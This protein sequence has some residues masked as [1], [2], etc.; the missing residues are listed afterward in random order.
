MVRN[1]YVIG[2]RVMSSEPHRGGLPKGDWPQSTHTTVSSSFYTVNFTIIMAKQRTK[3]SPKMQAPSISKLSA[4]QLRKLQK[5]IDKQLE[6]TVHKEEHVVIS[7]DDSGPENN[8]DVA[9]STDDDEYYRRPEKTEIVDNLHAV[10]E[11]SGKEAE[12]SEEESSE[13]ESSEEESSEEESSEEES[14]EEKSFEEEKSLDEEADSFE[15]EQCSDEEIESLEKGNYSEDEQESSQVAESLNKKAQQPLTEDED[16]SENL[17]DNGSIDD[18][19]EQPSD[20]QRIGKITPSW[21]SDRDKGILRRRMGIKADLSPQKQNQMVRR[22]RRI[23]RTR[24]GYSIDKP[25]SSYGRIIQNR[26]ISSR[27]HSERSSTHTLMHMCRRST[28]CQR[29]WLVRR[30]S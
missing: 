14:S 22:L 27:S 7:S 2:S 3:S 16:D 5:E 24:C 9:S 1:G 17:K 4:D 23:V 6:R 8:D 20:N 15:E 29:L 21:Y 26:M 25:W 18:D 28:P 13:E 12:S 11:K 10:E 19:H 30:V